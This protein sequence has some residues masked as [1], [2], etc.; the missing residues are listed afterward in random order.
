MKCMY[1]LVPNLVSTHQVSVDLQ[2]VGVDG[3][4][5]HVISKDEAGLKNEKIHSSNWLETTDLLH[6]GFVGANFGFII[7][8]LI[9]G[10]LLLFEPFGP[11]FPT[12]AYF[13]M[14]AVATGFG[15]WVG[16]LTG[17]DTENQKLSR[18]HSAIEEGKYLV[19][20]YA[21]KGEGEKIKEMMRKRHPESRHVATDRHFINPFGRLHR[22]RKSDRVQEQ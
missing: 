7:G 20:I 5:V 1:Y 14:V 13:F 15:A 3:W 18:F 16:G 11:D 19:L 10:S 2:D 9:A 17:L 12:I 6:A 8:V 22:R 4:Y 21:H